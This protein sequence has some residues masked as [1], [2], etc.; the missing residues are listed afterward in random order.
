MKVLAV[1]E[2]IYNMILYK[3]TNLISNSIYIGITSGGLKKRFNEHKRCAKKGVKT[4]LYCAMKSYGS[5]N[6]KIEVLKEYETREELELAEYETIKEFKE[7]DF[8]LYNMKDELCKHF[9]IKDVEKWKDKLKIKRKGRTPA[10]GMK[11]NDENKKKFSEFS[12]MRWDL[13]GRY[14]KEEIVKLSRKEAKEKFGISTT[15]YYRLR[16]EADEEQR[17]SLNINV[18]QVEV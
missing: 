17:T 13:Y 4:T 3:I 1:F 5:E 9:Y 11:H 7:L 16:K 6:F 15:H 12:K 2:V 8:N 10:L 14:P 18:N